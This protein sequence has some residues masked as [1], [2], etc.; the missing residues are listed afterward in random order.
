MTEGDGNSQE[1]AMAEAA[2]IVTQM[3]FKVC[4]R[5]LACFPLDVIL[6]NYYMV[7]CIFGGETCLL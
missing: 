5:Y 4:D 2:D 7:L 3:A 1:K 6:I